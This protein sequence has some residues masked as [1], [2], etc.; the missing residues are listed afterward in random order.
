MS[1]IQERNDYHQTLHK[2][3]HGGLQMHL[4]NSVNLTQL[5][6]RLMS[7]FLVVSFVPKQSAPPAAEL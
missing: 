1:V 4:L 3:N 5:F 6:C 2:Y 7:V